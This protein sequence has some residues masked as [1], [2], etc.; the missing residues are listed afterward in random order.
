[1][2]RRTIGWAKANS[3]YSAVSDAADGTPVPQ[4]HY[5]GPNPGWWTRGFD[6]ETIFSLPELRSS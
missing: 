5:G 3:A 4:E 6:Q 1:M 2:N